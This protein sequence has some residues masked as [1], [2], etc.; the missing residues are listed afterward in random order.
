M[1][2]FVNQ[3]ACFRKFPLERH[4]C[5]AQLHLGGTA[6]LRFSAATDMMLIQDS[7]LWF[8]IKHVDLN[9]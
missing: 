4:G 1:E 8:V 3:V 2:F 5:W 6:Y 9:K 7:H